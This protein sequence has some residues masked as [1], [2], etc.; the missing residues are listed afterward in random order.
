[1][2]ENSIRL[3]EENIKCRN[4]GKQTG[5]VLEKTEKGREAH[6]WLDRSVE[7]TARPEGQ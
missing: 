7:H 3:L 6:P 1:M 5:R 4:V 2:I